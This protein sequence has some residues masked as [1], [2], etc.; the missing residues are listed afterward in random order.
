MK[1]TKILIFLTIMC[2]SILGIINGNNLTGKHDNIMKINNETIIAKCVNIN[3]KN[4]KEYNEMNL[5]GNNGIEEQSKSY[6]QQ[7]IE[8]KRIINYSGIDKNQDIEEKEQ[9]NNKKETQNNESNFKEELKIEQGNITN[10]LEKGEEKKEP[11]LL[12]DNNVRINFDD[13]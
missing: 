12:K 11:R 7:K 6:S 10:L 5:D 9:Q 4:K 2:I 1:I 3:I 13:W 8:K